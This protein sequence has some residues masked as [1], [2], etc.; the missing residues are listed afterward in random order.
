MRRSIS[1]TMGFRV[2]AK[3][4]EIGHVDAFYFDDE[5][6][7]IRYL[8][9]NTGP[10]L[11]GKQVP[12]S[13]VLVKDVE[14]DNRCISLIVGADDIEKSPDVDSKMPIARRMEAAISK[15]YGY[16]MYWGGR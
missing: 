3:D 8:P 2:E 16:P 12:V 6:W 5:R 13:P 4:G 1:S 14:W 7:A 11:L 10:R 9:V 15:H